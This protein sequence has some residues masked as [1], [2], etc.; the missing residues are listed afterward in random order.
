VH[1]CSPPTPIDGRPDE[2]G[3]DEYQI[4]P[5]LENSD[6]NLG[7]EPDIHGLMI[8]DNPAFQSDAGVPSVWKFSSHPFRADLDLHRTKPDRVSTYDGRIRLR[9]THT[10]R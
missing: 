10:P 7:R 1:A 4:V 3:A 9:L 5:L 6:G 2:V 8:A